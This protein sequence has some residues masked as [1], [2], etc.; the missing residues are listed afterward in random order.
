[1]KLAPKIL[2]VLAVCLSI[3]IGASPADAQARFGVQGSYDSEFDLGVGARAQVG[4]LLGGSDNETLRRIVGIASFDYF[5]PSCEAF[6]MTFDC[7][8]W[9]LSGNVSLP[10][11]GAFGDA[12]TLV[13]YAGAGLSYASFTIESEDADS[14]IAPNLFGGVQF[15]LGG[16]SSYAEARFRASGYSQLILTFGVLFGG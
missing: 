11:P 1:M 15:G 2:A 14:G 16:L 4:P 8:Y 5:F 12:N 9:D 6:D 10:F 7:S 13:P 3:L